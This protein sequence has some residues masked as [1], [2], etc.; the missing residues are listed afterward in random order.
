MADASVDIDD[1]FG[2]ALIG[3][4]VASVLYGATILQTWIY[5]S[6]V[7]TSDLYRDKLLRIVHRLDRHSSKSDTRTTKALVF[8]LFFLDTMHLILCI[9]T[10]YWYLITN[11]NNPPAL[12]ASVWSMNIQ[13]DFN[14]LI[15]LFVEL[16]FARRVW[17]M[18]GNM[19]LTG[20]IV[21]LATIHFS[22]GVVFTVRGFAL[23]RFS[24][25]SEL[26]WVTC[27]G[28]GSAAAADII[29]AGAM[30]WYLFHS[31]TGFKR[32]D[33]MLMALM[34]YSINTGLVTSVVAT[35]AVITFAIMPTNFVWLACFWVLGKCYV[36]SF[37]AILNGRESIRE[38]S[39]QPSDGVMHLSAL[40]SVTQEDTLIS[41]GGVTS[42]SQKHTRPTLAVTVE[43]TTEYKSD[44]RSSPN[45]PVSTTFLTTPRT[46]HPQ[47]SPLPEVG[48]VD[49]RAPS[50]TSISIPHP[51]TRQRA[52]F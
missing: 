36:N 26:T 12:D 45:S 15:G 44:Y 3:L 29:I 42:I 10:I 30:C 47:L 23:G 14:G 24:L 39:T 48:S 4:L 31:R 50:V 17:M 40:R 38:R 7:S 2:A 9:R 21:I 27:T 41:H 49:S 33:S 5:F 19:L 8:S 13:T 20:V 37:L 43:T 22:L 25:Y 46:Q 11:Y 16:F 34:L 32:T 18:S 1:T 51:N 28:L 6:L 52:Y 35:T